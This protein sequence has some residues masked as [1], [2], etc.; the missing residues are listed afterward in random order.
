M[1][2]LLNIQK[3][4]KLLNLIV[5]FSTLRHFVTQKTARGLICGLSPLFTR[6]KQ[7]HFEEKDVLLLRLSL[8]RCS[9]QGRE[10]KSKETAANDFE[11]SSS[12]LRH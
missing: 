12:S 7:K 8:R 3:V 11:K 4:Y 2:V 6:Q 5:L 10:K 9:K 1:Y